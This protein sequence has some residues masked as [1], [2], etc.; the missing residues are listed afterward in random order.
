MT[1]SL[2]MD[3]FFNPRTVVGI[4]VSA[5]PGKLGFILAE[6]LLEARAADVF[7]VNPGAPEILGRPCFPS[8]E[9]VP[10]TPDLAVVAVPAARV[11]ET[12]MDCA[13]K[14]I[15]AAVVLAAGFAETG[16]AGERLQQRMSSV[17]REHS[18]RAVGPNTSGLYN[19]MTR[20]NASIAYKNPPGGG[21]ISFMTQSGAA[22]LAAHEYALD[23]HLQFAKLIDYG[24]QAD[25]KDVEILDYFGRDPETGV[26]AVFLEGLATGERFSQ[27]ADEAGGRK[28][29]VVGW[30]ARTPEGRRAARAHTGMRA[31]R[32]VG[33]D[34]VFGRAG[35]IQA[36]S[37][38]ETI[39]TA[40]ALDWQPLPAG[41]RVGI[42]SA[43]GGMAVELADMCAEHG[44]AVP[45][46]APA[47]Q[48]AIR[49][50]MAPFATTQ[51]PI[52]MGPIYPRFPEA[53]VRCIDVLYADSEI[54]III[55]TIADRGAAH[56]ECLEA[57]A[58]TVQSLQKAG[59]AQKPVYVS[60]ASGRAVLENQSI[61]E[62]VRVPC[63]EHSERTARIAGAIAGYARW[64]RQHARP[65]QV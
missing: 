62:A 21:S 4:G 37:M 39:E 56:V 33:A 44:L 31:G 52:D 42:I 58:S 47:A 65:V 7:F 35:V 43:S 19:C 3:V 32:G 26:V 49:P 6:N 8:L 40:K 60:W 9:N 36:R 29:I 57:I 34:A 46:L 23:H 22:V 14:E 55:I 28:P 15:R 54:D 48:E 20:L 18:I 61:L 41:S 38:L 13:R 59:A 63:F 5:Q 2:M 30:V 53:Y 24:N 45:E 17:C 12:L 11:V 51:N 25:V 64:R 50:W 10:V 27:L 1:E 16:S